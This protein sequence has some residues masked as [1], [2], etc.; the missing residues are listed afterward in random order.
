MRK[1]WKWFWVG[2]GFLLIGAGLIGEVNLVFALSWYGYPQ[3]SAASE[4]PLYGLMILLGVGLLATMVSERSRNLFAGNSR[5]KY[6]RYGWMGVWLLGLF[7]LPIGHYFLKSVAGTELPMVF[8]A[9][10]FNFAW[11]SLFPAPAVLLIWA[12]AVRTRDLSLIT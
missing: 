5:E 1:T 10:T 2:V 4:F 8:A 3:L 12:E 9:W 6:A 7:S 11:V